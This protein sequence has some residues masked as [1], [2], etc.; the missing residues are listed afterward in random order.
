MLIKK[1][2]LADGEIRTPTPFG[3]G[4]C[5]QCVYLFRHVCLLGVNRGIWTLRWWGIRAWKHWIFHIFSFSNWLKIG[6]HQKF[7][8]LEHS[9]AYL[10]IVEPFHNIL[11]LL[12]LALGLFESN[13]SWKIGQNPVLAQQR[14]RICLMT[15]KMVWLSNDLLLLNLHYCL[16]C[17]HGCFTSW[18]QH[19][20]WI[21]T[22]TLVKDKK[23]IQ[24][25]FEYW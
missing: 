4:L 6:K 18:S 11:A 14:G 7:C 16:G 1:I 5:V 25:I 23:L 2:S 13:I 24:Q 20:R 19:T 17:E 10:P 8:K 9:F 21:L 3:A 12:F 22:T 15:F